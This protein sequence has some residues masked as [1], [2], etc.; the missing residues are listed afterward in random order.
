MRLEEGGSG[1][2]TLRLSGERPE[3]L[4]LDLPAPPG[5]LHLLLPRPQHGLRPRGPS[6]VAGVWK[7]A[8]RSLRRPGKGATASVQK[9]KGWESRRGFT[10]A[11]FPPGG[12]L[13]SLD[14]TSD[15][16]CIPF[17]ETVALPGAIGL[18]LWLSFSFRAGTSSQQSLLF[19]SFASTQLSQRGP[20]SR[21]PAVSNLLSLLPVLLHC[22]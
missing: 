8:P 4:R 16:L 19:R 6:Q 17:L 5:C 15:D 18:C 2:R 11:S 10:A 7:K 13:R 14:L 21:V 3:R 20:A 22:S 1:R 12:W 9:A